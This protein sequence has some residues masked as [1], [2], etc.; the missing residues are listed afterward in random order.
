MRRECVGICG[1]MVVSW[2]GWEDGDECWFAILA[3]GNGTIWAHSQ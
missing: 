2:G 1:S 3:D